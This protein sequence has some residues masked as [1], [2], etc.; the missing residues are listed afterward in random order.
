MNHSKLK[1]SGSKY[2]TTSSYTSSTHAPSFMSSA[3]YNND[4]EYEIPCQNIAYNDTSI[5]SKMSTDT[6]MGGGSFDFGTTA[7][8]GGVGSSGFDFGS[9]G[10]CNDNF[11]S[12]GGCSDNYGGDIGTSDF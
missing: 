3:N 5:F 2:H 1:T 7:S 8:A 11:G 4:D 12:S 6:G 10:G 9:S